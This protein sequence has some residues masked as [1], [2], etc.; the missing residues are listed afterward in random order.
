V[1]VFFMI[2]CAELM[3]IPNAYAV[4]EVDV[5][6]F[7]L[8]KWMNRVCTSW[9]NDCRCPHKESEPDEPLD[10]VKSLASAIFVSDCAMAA[11]N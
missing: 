8:A 6:A 2:V 9:G 7:E 3:G 10:M 4:A 11:T 5:Q 1:S